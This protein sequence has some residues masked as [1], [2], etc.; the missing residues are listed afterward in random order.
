MASPVRYLMATNPHHR[1]NPMAVIPTPYQ[2]FFLWIEP[3]ATLVGAISAWFMPE[4]YLQMTDSGSAPGILGL[5]IATH[6]ALRQLGNLYLAF[7][8]SEALVLRSTTDLIVWRSFLLVLLIADFG[9]LYTCLP[10]GTGIYYRISNWDAIDWGNLGFVYCGVAMR[11][12]FLAGVGLGSK[13]SK[14][15]SRKPIDVKP[16]VGDTIVVDAA[17]EEPKT[18]K[19]KRGRKKKT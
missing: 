14:S 3:A 17:V 2:A 1:S 6:I 5:P 19:S 15:K 10:L 7:A 13:K 12:C 16:A 11:T 18:P 9:H 8:L 4:A